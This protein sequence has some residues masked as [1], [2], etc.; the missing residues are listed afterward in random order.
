M[1]LKPVASYITV[2]CHL[3]IRPTPPSSSHVLPDKDISHLHLT[4]VFWIV[5]ILQLPQLIQLSL[6]LVK[7]ASSEISLQDNGAV[8]CR[9]GRLENT[10]DIILNTTFT[11]Q[12][13]SCQ[14]L[15]SFYCL[16]RKKSNKSKKIVTPLL[17]GWRITVD[18]T[19]LSFTR[20]SV[21]QVHNKVANGWS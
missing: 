18:W 10:V 2:K 6:R 5:I 1:L 20:W 12:W 16:R 4:T 15:R 11:C 21:C 14:W 19:L 7:A 13:L 3:V 8:R 9:A 17:K